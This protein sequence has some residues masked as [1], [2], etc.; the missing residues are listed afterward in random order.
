MIIRLK[1]FEQ[2][3]SI[4]DT[5]SIPRKGSKDYLVLHFMFSSD[6]NDF[7]KVCY[8][9]N[10]EV[11]QPIDVVDN[12]VEVP[13]WFTEQDCFDVTL[14]GKSGSKEVP[15]N[16]VSLRL[17]K[18][19]TLWEQGAP[20]PQPSWLAK[21]IDLNNHPS[22]PGQNGFWL[23]WDTDS[24]AYV[25]SD[26]PLPAISVGPQGP[27]GEKGDKGDAFTY[28]DFT[29]EQLAALKGEKGDTGAIGPQG[30]RGEQGPKGDT[31]A[32]GPKGNTGATGPQGQK[33]EPGPQGPKGDAGATGATGPQGPK[34]DKGDTGPAGVGVPNG[35][36]AGQLLSK[37][38]SGTEWIDPPQSGVQPDWNQNDD[39]KPD[40]VKNRPFYV[41]D[42]VETVLL[43]ESTLSFEDEMGVYVANFSQTSSVT[44][45]ET[46]KVSWDGTV[47]ECT[48]VNMRDAPAIGNLSI[49]GAGS[50]TGEP[51]L[52]RFDGH[53]IV[54][55]TL[56]TSASHT[57]SISS[58]AESVVKIDQKYLPVASETEP[59]IIS[60][61]PLSNFIVQQV[62]NEYFTETM[63]PVF[64][65]GN[66]AI[67]KEC[68]DKNNSYGIYSSGK[69]GG[70]VLSCYNDAVN[71]YITSV[72]S[73]NEEI[74]CWKF[75]QGSTTMEQLWGISKDGVV[76]SSSTTGST[77][78]FRITV[79]DSGTISATELT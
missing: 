12:L 10:G 58:Y 22:I 77:K 40:Y 31:G 73:G 7:N 35:G 78:K 45:G 46:Y 69:F 49:A 64:G 20:E 37:T 18:S 6:W 11:S 19:N 55:G 75:A 63:T 66:A 38:E 34:G 54:I 25:E 32:V 47:Y 43:E 74:E 51:F 21:V 29:A 70:A 28:A 50:D 68:A 16:V 41:G 9:Q 39:T 24:G 36:I 5:K 48:C 44:V 8:L 57:I 17:E 26:L 59:G 65:Y 15:T 23:I 42:H 13:E 62:K 60:V 1:V 3:L 67:I 79:D 30:P 72:L 14:F 27:Q 56:D 76:I 52:M 61:N 33:G 2:T 4:V 71:K 53:S